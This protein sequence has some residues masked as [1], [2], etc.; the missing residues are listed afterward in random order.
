MLYASTSAYT[1]RVLN[2]LDILYT[3]SRCPVCRRA[4][5]SAA[6]CCSTCADTLF[7][8][9]VTGYQLV[10][11]TY[12]G[13]LETAVRALK[14]HHAT[15]LATLFGQRLAAEVK[16]QAWPV[17]LVCPVP[18]HPRRQQARG[19]NQSALIAKAVARELEVHYAVPLSRQ[20]A[21][22]QQAR[23]S[24]HERRENV[25]GA[26][27]ARALHGQPVLLVDDVVTSGATVTE[28][29]LALIEAGAGMTFVAAVAQAKPS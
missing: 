19:Y 28:C 13:K 5:S 4:A 22:R 16:R 12:H 7:T 1:W 14:F 2:P 10:L 20:R 29:S 27:K 23:L 26:F 8:P 17:S 15:R 25:T 9:Q 18:L 3:L 24:L 11:G 21:T 6:G